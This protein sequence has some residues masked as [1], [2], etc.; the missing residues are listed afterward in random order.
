[1]AEQSANAVK[2]TTSAPTPHCKQGPV[3]W[4]LIAGAFATLA[5]AYAWLLRD[6]GGFRFG[7]KYALLLLPLAAALIVFAVW[8]WRSVRRAIT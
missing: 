1:M 2:R 8:R 7:H 6:A 4:P 5:A 3:P